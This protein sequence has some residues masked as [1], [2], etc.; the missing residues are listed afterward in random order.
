MRP[1]S[2]RAAI[3]ARGTKPGKN[4]ITLKVRRAGRG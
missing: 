4:V 2:L 1:V 3:A